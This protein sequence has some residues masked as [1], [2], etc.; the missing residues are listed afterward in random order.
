[1]NNFLKRNR[2][3]KLFTIGWMSLMTVIAAFLLFGVPSPHDRDIE[4][5]L[6]SSGDSAVILILM[7]DN[8]IFA[9]GSGENNILGNCVNRENMMKLDEAPGW[10]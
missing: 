9:E 2:T 1:M 10:L 6:I 4:I 7:P 3:I 5:I 8:V